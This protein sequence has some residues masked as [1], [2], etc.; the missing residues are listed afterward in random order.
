MLQPVTHALLTGVGLTHG[1]FTREGGVSTGLYAGLNCGPGSGD[2]GGNVAENRRRVASHF[3]KSPAHLLTCHQVHSADVVAVDAPF[4]QDARP[5][6]DALVTTR[7][8][9]I[10]GILTADCAPVLFADTEARVIGAAHAG[11]KGAVGGVLENTIAAMET[12]G[13]DRAR[14]KAVIGPAIAQPSYEVNAEFYA[15]FRQEN[16]D[17]Q[18]FFTPNAEG[19]YQFNLPA[20]VRHRLVHAGVPHAADLGLDTYP[21]STRFFSFRRTTH[22]GE[23]DYGRQVSCIMLA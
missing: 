1:F 16:A 17:Y 18:A 22:A 14:I 21:E 10:L 13:A 8:G 4:S 5:K 9:L 3:Q 15:R 23:A 6:V 19:K 7:P 11:W 20:F 12:L 2:D